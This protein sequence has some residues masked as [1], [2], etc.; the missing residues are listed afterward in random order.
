MATNYSGASSTFKGGI[1][2]ILGKAARDKSALCASSASLLCGLQ[3][4]Y[5]YISEPVRR[6]F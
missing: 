5:G 1:S 4:L 3:I 6:S 2:I